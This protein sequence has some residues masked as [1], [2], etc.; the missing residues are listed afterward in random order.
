MACVDSEAERGVGCGRIVTTKDAKM[1]S[2]SRCTMLLCCASCMQKTA[3]DSRCNWASVGSDYA[4]ACVDSEAEMGVRRGR[5]VK[6]KGA[7]MKSRS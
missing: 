4:M 3:A 7:K 5:L 6:T 2:R 1:K